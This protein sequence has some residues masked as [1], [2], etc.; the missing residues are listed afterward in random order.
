[1]NAMMKTS[2]RAQSA[3]EYL[4]TYGWAILIIAVVLGA[5]YVL[6]VFNGTSFLG[7]SCIAGSGF[8]C[9]NLLLHT[10][11]L[12]FSFGQA[13]GNDW[14][15]LTLYAVPTGS[16]TTTLTSDANVVVSGGLN[17][18]Q[19][20]PVSI[21]LSPAVSTGSTWSGYI[22]AVYTQG[23]TPNLQDQVAT[24]TAKAT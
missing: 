8:Q 20:T 11:D 7:T 22:Y 12:S 23:G 14:T 10:S 18:G 13:T 15:A 19:T 6:G 4:M 17:S 21:A 24:V 3:M 9:T 2:K 16:S 5:L 1:M